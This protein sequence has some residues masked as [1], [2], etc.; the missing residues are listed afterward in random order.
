MIEE[1]VAEAE[2]AET[3]SVPVDTL[4]SFDVSV[5]LSPSNVVLFLVVVRCHFSSGSGALGCSLSTL[6]L[7]L[8]SPG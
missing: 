6:L 1:S 7:L 2:C 8:F 5:F 4:T 3:E